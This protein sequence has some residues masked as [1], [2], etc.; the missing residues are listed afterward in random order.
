MEFIV[1]MLGKDVGDKEIKYAVRRVNRLIS[2]LPN[3]AKVSST[4]HVERLYGIQRGFRRIE[5]SEVN[6]I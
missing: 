3:W 1:E 6:D 2:R 5:D 4:R